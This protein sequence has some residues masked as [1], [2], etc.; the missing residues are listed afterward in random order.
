MARKQTNKPKDAPP[1][2]APAHPA[3]ARMRRLLREVLRA[4]PKQ[5]FTFPALL[6]QMEATDKAATREL[7]Q[8]ALEWN[9][10]Q[11]NVNF[12]HDFE[13]EADVWKITTRGLNAP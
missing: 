10:R 11:G 8:A 9:F 5:P 4:E 7:V 12:D 3:T 2:V 1:V 6:A 13:L